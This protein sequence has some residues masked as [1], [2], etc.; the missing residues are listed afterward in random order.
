MRYGSPAL[1]RW[2]ANRGGREAAEEFA[3][4]AARYSDETLA[5]VERQLKERKRSVI[6]VFRSLPTIATLPCE[7]GSTR[8]EG[9]ERAG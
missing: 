1:G 6:P 7:E 2:I 5:K 3:E 4:Q 9:R 8:W